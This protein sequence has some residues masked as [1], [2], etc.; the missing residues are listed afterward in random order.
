MQDPAN[1]AD[2]RVR[3]TLSY[4]RR[5]KHHLHRYAQSLGYLDWATQPDPFRTFAGAPTVPL[6]LLADALD[7]SSRISTRPERIAPRRWMSTASACYSSWRSGCRPGRSTRARAGRCAATRPAATCI[8]PRVTPSCRR[9]RASRPASTTTSAATT[10]WNAVARSPPPS[11]QPRRV[12]AAGSVSGRPVVDPLA[13]G[14]E[15]WRTRLPLLPARRRPRPRRDP[16]RR[17]GAG[18]VGPVARPSRRCRRVRL[19]RPERARALPEVD[20]L[21]REHP[22]AIV[23][24]GPPPLPHAVSGLT[25]PADGAWS[26]KAN[27]LSPHHVHWEVIDDVAEATWRRK[28]TRLFFTG[29]TVA[30][31]SRVR[32]QASVPAATLIRQRRSC[33]A[34]DGRTDLDVGPVLSHPRPAA[35]AAGRAALGSA[36]LGA[37]PARRRLCPPRYGLRPGLYFFERSPAVHDELRHTCRPTFAWEKPTGCPDELAFY[38]LAEGDSRAQARTVSCHQDIAADGAFSS[39]HDRGIRRH[40]SDERGVVV[41]APV[42]G[43]GRP[44][45]RALPGGGGGWSARHRDRLLLRRR[46]ARYFGPARRPLAG[47]LPF[48]RGRTGRGCATADDGAVRTSRTLT[49]CRPYGEQRYRGEVQRTTVIAATRIGLHLWPHGAFA[50]S[51]STNAECSAVAVP[52]CTHASTAARSPRSSASVSRHRPGKTSLRKVPAASAASR[53]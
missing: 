37:A 20:P 12:L 49:G 6:P 9:C 18:L 10:F 31:K 1:S 29:A 36:A 25:T 44:R 32:R 15:V 19:A 48:H 47:P 11:P 35:A 51:R 50:H 13:R 26:G 5:T 21:D 28:G 17:G 14:V 7:A 30:K 23:L 16:L 39:R 34:L 53:S 52:R 42:L 3:R 40:H 24:V 45:A 41:S 2:D 46:D 33:L 4:H 27:R 38:L 43:G 8:R 22:D